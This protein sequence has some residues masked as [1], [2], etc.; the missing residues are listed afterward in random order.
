MAQ[1]CSDCGETTSVKYIISADN[2]ETK[3]TMLIGYLCEECWK[4]TREPRTRR[5][6]D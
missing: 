4:R 3:E 1:P 5:I 2:V 6:D